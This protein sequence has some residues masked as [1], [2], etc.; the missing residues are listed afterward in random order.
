[1]VGGGRNFASRRSITQAGPLPL[2]IPSKEIPVTRVNP[3]EPVAVGA[4]FGAEEP[5]ATGPKTGVSAPGGGAPEGDAYTRATTTAVPTRLRQQPDYR[6]ATSETAA[7]DRIS[8]E[9]SVGELPLR[10][11]HTLHGSFVGVPFQGGT[12]IRKEGFPEVPVVKLAFQTPLDANYDVVVTDVKFREVDY[13]GDWIPS[14]GTLLRSQ[15]PDDVA[16]RV[17]PESVVDEFF[18]GGGE[19]FVRPGSHFRVRA[20][21]GYELEVAPVQVNP[22]RKKVR[23]LESVRFDLVP[24]KGADQAVVA[25]A[26]ERPA[27]LREN[28]GL[29]QTMFPNF[30]WD[31]EIKDGKGDVLVVHTARDAEAIAPLVEHKRSLGFSVKTVEVAAGT[32]VRPLVQEEYRKNPDLMY[33][34]NVGDWQDIQVETN[35]GGYPEDNELGMVA[36]DDTFVDLAVGRFS[37]NSAEH[38]AA[39][40]QKTIAY[41]KGAL[42]PWH[43]RALAIGSAEGAGAGDDGESDFQHQGVIAEHKLKPTGFGKVT[44]VYD[45]AASAAAVAQ[46]VDE[47]VGVI[48][49]TGHGYERGW[50]TSGFSNADIANLNNGEQT[51]IIFSVACVN[52][53]YHLAGDSFAEAWLRKENGGAV[54]ALMATIYQ[55][56]VDPMIGQ[57]YINDMVAGGYDYAQK[58]GDGI[59]TDHGKK[60]LGAAVFNALALMRAEMGGTA[61]SD[62]TIKTWALFG[63][64]TLE[65]KLPAEAPGGEGEE[66]PAA[67]D[68]SGG[69][70]TEPAGA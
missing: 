30:R 19:G 36:G 22:A 3:N 20:V 12:V 5:P 68:A 55:P 41:E 23:I 53:A 69:E 1:M 9:M 42:K 58:P 45:P 70:R 29:Y 28:L 61:S 54:A 33:V 26:P 65:M 49:Y 4:S 17:A 48:N 32:Q 31:H 18:P 35:A 62:D 66:P 10:T 8:V 37:A 6:V 7:R 46:A 14:K 52:G 60:H 25:A 16:P 56:W 59:S 24:R 40:V 44:E 47:G 64:P 34:L 63:D 67:A 39:Q 13:G 51:P 43:A 38:V 57:D 21:R 11:L 15:S 27:I 50:V 2:P